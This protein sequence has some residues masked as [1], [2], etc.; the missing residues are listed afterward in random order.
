MAACCSIA[1]SFI[2]LGVTKIDATILAI[3]QKAISL[4]LVISLPFLGTGLIVGLLI[5][6]FQAATQI[7][8]MT[9]AFV[10]KIFA[11]VLAGIFFGPWILRVMVEFSR[12][13]LLSIPGMVK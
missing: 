3:G 1:L 10:P 2:P 9:I 5:S 6:V 12:S 7:Q 11:V 13:L 8:E 4:A